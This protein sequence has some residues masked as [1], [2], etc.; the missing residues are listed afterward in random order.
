MK[1]STWPPNPSLLF[2]VYTSMA[3]SASDTLAPWSAFHVSR[4]ALVSIQLLQLDRLPQG[5]DEEQGRH[6]VW[7]VSCVDV[8]AT[9]VA[10]SLALLPQL[11]LSAPVGILGKSA[12]FR[13]RQAHH[14][15]C[16]ALLLWF[17]QT[18]ATR[19]SRTPHNDCPESSEPPD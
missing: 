10:I 15:G 18:G 6:Q 3:L 17:T 19:K 16:V 12:L 5:R 1:E 7:R 14:S 4:S 2:Q 13:L 11:L 8:L 9:E